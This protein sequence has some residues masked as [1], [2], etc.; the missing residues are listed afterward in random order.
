M[1]PTITRACFLA[2]PFLAI[3]LF[4][5]GVPVPSSASDLNTPTYSPDFR[6]PWK[7][8]GEATLIFPGGG[9]G[10]DPMTRFGP[11][12]PAEKG[13]VFL[14]SVDLDG[15]AIA[16][17]EDNCPYVFNPVQL[18]WDRDGTGDACETF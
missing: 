7:A 3:S 12:N 14:D 2:L 13:Y 16:D 1:S 8:G 15:D 4:C 10:P 11:D 17:N 6:K 5:T 18:D 9:I